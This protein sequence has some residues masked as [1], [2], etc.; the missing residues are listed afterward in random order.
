MIMAAIINLIASAISD[1]IGRKKAFNYL[2]L[3]MLSI[4]WPGVF[5]DSIYIKV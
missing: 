3:I 4:S 2:S 5:F 1:Y